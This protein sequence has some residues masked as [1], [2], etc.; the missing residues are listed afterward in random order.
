MVRGSGVKVMGIDSQCGGPLAYANTVG[1]SLE[2]GEILGTKFR[3]PKSGL[4]CGLSIYCSG[5]RRL[6]FK[7]FSFIPPDRLKLEVRH[8][9]GS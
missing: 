8:F 6:K 4:F 1:L 2:V 5:Y 7:A 3:G 9:Y